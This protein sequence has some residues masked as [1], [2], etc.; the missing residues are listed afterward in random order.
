MASD[1]KGGLVM[2]T[3]ETGATRDSND[4]KLAYTGFFSPLVLNRRAH[5]MHAHRVQA[6]G[7]VREAN[8]WKKG[9]SPEVYLESMFRHVMDL[10]ILQEG[11]SFID[12]NTDEGFQVEEALCAI[13]FNAEGML[14]EILKDQDSLVYRDGDSLATR[15]T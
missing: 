1:G 11:G 8:N 4:T 5:Y 7:N 12:V 10:W 2:R 13:M 15:A 14:H 9:M 6:D 3:F